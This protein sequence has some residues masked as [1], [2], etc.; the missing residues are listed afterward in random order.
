MRRSVGCSSEY[1]CRQICYDEI[2]KA[3]A[4]RHRNTLSVCLQCVTTTH[5]ALSLFLLT[6]D[7]IYDLPPIHC[8]CFPHYFTTKNQCVVLQKAINKEI[9]VL[10]RYP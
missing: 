7:I 2:M 8:N 4:F 5:C 9:L 10:I 3:A 1:C 6:V